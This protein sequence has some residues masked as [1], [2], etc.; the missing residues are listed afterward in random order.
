MKDLLKTVDI[1]IAQMFFMFT[2]CPAKMLKIVFQFTLQP[3]QKTAEW[4]E[5]DR[6]TD[7]Y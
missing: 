5:A 4:P 1:H 6:M 3:K 7:L 2:E